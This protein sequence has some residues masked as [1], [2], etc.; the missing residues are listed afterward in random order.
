MM[1]AVTAITKTSKENNQYQ[2]QKHILKH[3]PTSFL[4]YIFDISC[5]VNN[6]T[7]KLKNMKT[8]L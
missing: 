5:N 8:T 4:F 1:A 6:E 7:D 2:Y 3:L